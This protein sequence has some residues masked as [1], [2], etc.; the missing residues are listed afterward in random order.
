MNGQ[1]L[2]GHSQSINWR[3]VLKTI[4]WIVWAL[5]LTALVV[6]LVAWPIGN[7]AAQ[8]WQIGEAAPQTIFAPY[9]LSYPSAVMTEKAREAAAAQIAPIYTP[10]DPQIARQQVGKL[11]QTLEAIA[12]IREEAL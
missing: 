3:R 11:R 2:A 1:A 9:E 5:T 4:E 12:R 8:A 7:R 10:P 6:G